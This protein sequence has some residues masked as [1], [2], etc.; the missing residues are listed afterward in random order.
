MKKFEFELLAFDRS[1]LRKKD[2]SEFAKLS[3]LGADGWR[4]VHVKED[5][6]HDRDLL[7]FLERETS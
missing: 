5:P 6:Q 2:S 3:A 1:E 7:V 4:I